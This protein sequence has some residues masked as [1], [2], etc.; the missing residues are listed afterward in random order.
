[1]LWIISLLCFGS[2]FTSDLTGFKADGNLSGIGGLNEDLAV[3][4]PLLGKFRSD[5]VELKLRHEVGVEGA[6]FRAIIDFRNNLFLVY[7]KI[8][9]LKI[10]AIH[11]GSLRNDRLVRV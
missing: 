3:L 5:G 6:V 7:L 2:I 10:V 9:T 4:E 11:Y 1:V 8:S